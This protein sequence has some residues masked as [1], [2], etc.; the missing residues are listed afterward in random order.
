MVR[1]VTRASPVQP[2]KAK[3]GSG[4]LS[5]MVR[6]ARVGETRAS[7]RALH[8]APS[9]PGPARLPTTGG[10]PVLRVPHQAVGAEALQSTARNS[11]MACRGSRMRK[12]ASPVRG[13]GQGNP[14]PHA[15]ATRSVE[16]PEAVMWIGTR[17]S[18]EM[19]GRGARLHSAGKWDGVRVF[20]A[21]PQRALELRRRRRGRGSR[22][23][24]SEAATKPGAVK[25]TCSQPGTCV[26]AVS[27]DLRGARGPY[28][29]TISLLA[30]A[31][32]LHCAQPLATWFRQSSSIPPRA[33][34]LTH[35]TPLFRGS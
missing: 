17:P 26:N 1:A 15:T 5:E 16:I 33:R 28:G 21:I 31:E 12:S 19:S 22:S 24:R 8:E 20:P 11:P 23:G 7:G 25:V 35:P 34:D 3:D 10:D 29:G 4:S 9:T 13:G 18:L 30:V 2:R 32:A 27:C 6:P 14:G